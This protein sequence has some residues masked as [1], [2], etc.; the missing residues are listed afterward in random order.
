MQN[1]Y[2]Q[3]SKILQWNI[4]KATLGSKN[5]YK[6]IYNRYTYTGTNITLRWYINVLNET[7]E[8]KREN[9]ILLYLHFCWIVYISYGHSSVYKTLMLVWE[10]ETLI[11]SVLDC[12][13]LRP[14]S[15]LDSVNLKARSD[16]VEHWS[17]F[18]SQHHAPRLNNKWQFSSKFR[19]LI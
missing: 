18:C 17:A 10:P 5:A 13:I 12:Q 4:I 2:I 3:V 11:N 8:N 19:R 16:I 7:S 9:L 14:G 6:F 15:L 1:T